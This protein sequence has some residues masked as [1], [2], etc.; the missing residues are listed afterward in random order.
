MEQALVSIIIPFYNEENY[1]PRAVRSA[2]QQTYTRV[3]IILV[4]DGSTDNSL[5]IAMRYANEFSNVELVSIPH[6][7]L[8]KARNTGLEKAQGEYVAF[9]DSD[10]ELEVSA[11]EKLLAK[12]VNHQS[13]I[14]ICKFSVYDTKQNPVNTIGWKSDGADIDN[15]EAIL[16]LYRHE[17]VFMSCARLYKRNLITYKFPEGLWFEDTPFLLAYLLNAQNI[18]FEESSLWKI[19]SR[20]GSI[21]RRMIEERRIKDAYEIFQLE[22]ELISGSACY[23]DLKNDFF[24]YQ[25][26]PILFNLIILCQDRNLVS[27]LSVLKQCFDQCVRA[28]LSEYKKSKA[29]FGPRAKRDLLILRS[30]QF[31]GWDFTFKCLPFI[32]WKQY[33]NIKSLRTV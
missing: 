23:S 22:L 12:M 26:Q 7:S 33:R 28:Y 6:H 13:D 1:L 5:K 4:D 8:G 21:T 25:L 9:L 3:E 24:R 10:D 31:M 17:M 15:A 18:S 19:H 27:N 16:R 14:V 30:H 32:K 29:T 20:P 11:I 2:L